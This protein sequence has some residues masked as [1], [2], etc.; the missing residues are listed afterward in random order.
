MTVPKLQLYLLRKRCPEPV[1][2]LAPNSTYFTQTA[3]GKTGF[4]PDVEV[5]RGD[6]ALN[7]TTVPEQLFLLV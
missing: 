4:C 1:G 2:F 7:L 5:Q 6:A 3:D